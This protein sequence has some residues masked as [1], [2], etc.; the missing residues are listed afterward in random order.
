MGLTLAEIQ[1]KT[2]HKT[3]GHYSPKRIFLPIFSPRLCGYKFREM[4]DKE[5]KMV[6]NSSFT[7][8]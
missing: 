4:I 3:K 8:R 5:V 1:K 6:C 7:D 2:T